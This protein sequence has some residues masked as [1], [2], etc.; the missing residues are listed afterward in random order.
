MKKF[1][2]MMAAFALMAT[3][4]WALDLQTARTQG[5]VGETTSGYIQATGGGS[6]V[7]ALVTEVNAKRK[8]EY[9]RISAE[10]GQPIDV[11]AKVAAGTI[12]SNL[13]KG[14]KY[15]TPGGVWATK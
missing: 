4:A 13:P 10:N 6:E 14:A 2:T 12:I 3:P 9:A 8:T 11:V 5:V 15:Q 1:T 7:N